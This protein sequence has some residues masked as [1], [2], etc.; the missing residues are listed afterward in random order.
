M[1][2][3]SSG[4]HV[5]EAQMQMQ[6]MTVRTSVRFLG[7][8]LS[9][10]SLLFSS[11]APAA[12]LYWSGNGTT[13]GGNGTW[14]T[15][16]TRWGTVPAGP[17]STVWNN[18]NLDTA[19]FGGTAGTATL[20]ATVD[21][22]GL[23][24]NTTGYG[25]TTT[26][27]SLNFSATNNVI[28]FNNVAAATITGPIG[29]SGNVALTAANTNTAGTLTLNGTSTVG[30]SG[31]TTINS[32]MTLALAAGNQGLNST[33][34]IT[35][36]GGAIT[37]TNTSATAVTN[38]RVSN[39]A[40]ITS[41]GGSFTYTNTSGT[42]VYAETTGTVALTSGQMNFVLGTDQTGAGS[43][44][45]TLSGLTQAG[46]AAV[47][48]SAATTAP[49][50]TKNRIQVSGASA[51]PA[52]Q[53]IGPWATT[54][55]A[56]NG[57]NDYA[58]Y[59]ASGF[60]VPAN[61]AAS[62]VT[63]W[64][65]AANAYTLSTPAKTATS[66]DVTR[67]IAALKASSTATVTSSALTVNSSTFTIASGNSFNVG[68]PVMLSSLSGDIG[69]NT[70]YPQ[71]TVGTVYYVA[72]VTGTTFTLAPTPGGTA[73]TAG[74]AVTAQFTGGLKLD[75]GINLGTYGILNS[76]TAPLAIG[77]TAAGG[78]LT[79]PT[80][81]TG[82]LY[83]TTG[84]ATNAGVNTGL[85]GRIA[86][87]ATIVDNGGPLTLVKNGAG[88]LR[89]QGTNSYTGGT[90]INAGTVIFTNGTSGGNFGTG[91]ITFNG[92]GA[93]SFGPNYSFGFAQ[94]G[95]T[96]LSRPVTVN[97]GAIAGFYF[98]TPNTTMNISGDI[99]G[100][101][102]I[103]SGKDPLI[104]Y[105]GGDGTINISFT[106][107]GN[108]FTGPL[109]INNVTTTFNSLGDG[110]GP[111]ILNAGFTYGS[112]AVASLS[113]PNRLVDVRASTT[114]TN[115][116]SSS[117]T[118]TLGNI[119]TTT[120]GAKT[121]TLSNSSTN[122]NGFVTGDIT[123]GSGTISVTKA[124]TG[125]WAL[126][127]SNTY[128]GAT[129]VSS[130][131]GRLIFQGLQALPVSST[132][133]LNQLSSSASAVSFLTDASGTASL[134]NTLVISQANAVNN[135]A[136]FVGNNNTA[137]GGSSSGT[138]TDTT[139]SLALLRIGNITNN[140]NVG[141][142]LSGSNNYRLRFDNT[143]MPGNLN[144]Q[145]SSTSVR[146]SANSAPLTLA[147]TIR[148][149]GTSGTN[150]AP[151]TFILDGTN[152][153]SE[154]TGVIANGTGAN[155]LPLNVTKA[156]AGTWQLTG[157]NTYTGTTTV[158]G[159]ILAL[160]GVGTL[161]V[162]G[163]S[164]VVL[165]GGQL[166]LGTTSQTVAG[167]T[168]SSAFAS[169][170][171]LQGG[172]LNGS[173]FTFSNTTGSGTVTTNLIGSGA[174][175]KTAGGTV[176]LQGT[177][178]Y[179]GS[180]SVLGAL[181]V[182]SAGAITGGGGVTVGGAAALSGTFN[183]NTTASSTLGA[184]IIG[185]GND[186]AGNAT[187]NQTSGSI[188]GSS[189]ILNNSF[190]GQGAGDLTISGGSMNITGN[191]V[192]SNSVASAAATYSTITVS[193]TSSLTIGGSLALTGAPA[194]ARNGWGRFTQG[195]SSSV[196]I[197]GALNMAQTTV[198]NTNT[199][200]GEYNLNGGLLSVALITQDAGVDTTGTFNFNSGTLAPNAS[201]TTFMQG[202]TAAN[203]RNGGAIIDSGT[204][205]ITIAQNLRHS[206]IGGDAAIDGGLRKLG[207]GLLSLSG[208]NT[209]T[210]TTTVNAGTLQF[211]Q[212][213]ALYGGTTANWTQSRIN[214]K[215][216]AT[217]G[218]SVGGT[219]EF[220]TGNVTTLLTNLASSTSASTG[221]NAGSGFAFDTTNASGGSFTIAD[222]IAN[223]TGTSGGVRSVTKLGTG[224]LVLSGSNTYTGNT[225]V[226]AGTLAVTGN[227][228]TGTVSVA[229][230][231]WL[232]GTGTIAGPV[233]V[234]GNLS[235]G[236]SPGIL[237]VGSLTLLGSST[238]SVE[239]NDIVRGVSYD[240]IDITG[241]SSP[242]T[243][244]GLFSIAFGNVSAFADGT[245][246]D[247]FNFTGL[248]SGTFD[249]VTS[250]GFYAGTWTNIGSGT[251]E[252]ASGGQT[253]TFSSSTGDIVIVVPEPA[254]LAACGLGLVGVVAAA[255][256]RMARRG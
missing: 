226:S 149:T 220:T 106:G 9:I 148:Q 107:T 247:V 47:T 175:N 126:S 103:I 200:N 138:T 161:G 151:L 167:V 129:S 125:T 73:I 16:L 251:F 203:V 154:V 48:F 153:G 250:S 89:L 13:Q 155:T 2:F 171:T 71:F 186:G 158:S 63:T 143:E 77:R 195:G 152:T 249:S 62:L 139:I 127:G 117:R 204:F 191:V 95:T 10:G 76:G 31:A 180:T 38:N 182:N 187:F 29:G 5:V 227:L 225:L 42:S 115:S 242:L 197:A 198:S 120:A 201:T 23:Q 211:A 22:G 6:M 121:L 37:L 256:R 145:G 254:T 234:S 7:A 108:T 109:T 25:I 105:G 231:A 173:S 20:G 241:T 130:G 90:V 43:Q 246:F 159:G 44:T 118:V 232:Q 128:T 45:L 94:G 236:N 56:A 192:A 79:L 230:A 157:A 54:G 64:T 172:S 80:S 160:S 12:P 24:F 133:T 35:L 59:D 190:T 75:S 131:G 58:V 178:S 162:S 237:T 217:L 122:G 134:P 61:I 72:S 240:G 14:D 156:S 253:L 142:N 205:A 26:G 179:N 83:V 168:V 169:G 244:G 255:R 224:R 101:G 111:M 81:G 146:L 60:V 176:I 33:S 69:Q 212:S 189:L 97:N 137:N 68:D 214:V 28:L 183:Y 4:R 36:N 88:A 52:G 207:T 82:N 102:G 238:T 100:D 27:F 46:S 86:I 174:L 147:G 93:L 1:R 218:L 40:G 136:V 181:T 65:N 55:T 223:S 219:G 66:L 229:A 18:G 116:A 202:L 30:W 92:S 215:N 98:N 57:Q 228:S 85:S 50:A 113:I 87:D 119:S 41:N 49:N 243:Y 185:N 74:A 248:Y 206:T 239:I 141:F 34:G 32:G 245:V 184:I 11:V 164:N 21:V 51:T 99:T 78:Q 199:R 216:G 235:P 170:N 213:A 84:L 123:N 222:V 188:V 53:I 132:V 193:G 144:N 150:A 208:S 252:L 177:N 140:E 91:G 70:T 209:Y 196:S 163:S 96:S 3:V 15:T 233:V 67:N 165:S 39:S 221:M 110:S 19:I 8:I 17:F 194:A 104:T 114:L 124:G 166:N 135:I 112:G 210:G